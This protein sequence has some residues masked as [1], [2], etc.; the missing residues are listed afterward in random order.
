MIDLTQLR[1]ERA[2]LAVTRD[3]LADRIGDRRPTVSEWG[4][5]MHLTRQIEALDT[6][7]YQPSEPIIL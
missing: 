4:E 3:A 6:L 5:F 7:I 1:A 2:A